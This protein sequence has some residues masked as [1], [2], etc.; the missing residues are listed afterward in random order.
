MDK[1][2]FN[3]GNST[4]SNKETDGRRNN[5]KRALEEASTIEDV[6][7]VI[8]MVK[9][10]AIDKQDINAAKLYL[11]YYL[12]KPKESLDVTSDGERITTNF[13]DIIG[14]NKPE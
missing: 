10:K 8:Q 13:G 14:F 5:F 9:N 12:G 1:R 2:K 11:E 7:N 6:I 3:G 4:K